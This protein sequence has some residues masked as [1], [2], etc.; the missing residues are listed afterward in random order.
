MEKVVPATPIGPTTEADSP[1]VDASEK[2]VT[3]TSGG[4]SYAEGAKVCMVGYY[5]TCTSRGWVK[6]STSPC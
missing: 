3:C 4:Y 5:H 1:I 6:D 2:R